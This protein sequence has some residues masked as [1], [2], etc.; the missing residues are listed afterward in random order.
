ME[1]LKH[2]DRQE[3]WYQDWIDY[4]GEHGLYASLLSPER[5]SSRRH[6]LDIAKLARFLEAFAYFSPAHGYSLHVSLLGLFPILMSAN[7]ALKKEAIA[8]LEAG[9]LF[10]FAV[11]ERAHG[12][13]LFANEFTM[14]PAKAPAGP[15]AASE[16]WVAHGAKFYIGN[17]NAACLISILARKADPESPGANKRTPFAFFAL[18]PQETT[19]LRNVTKIRTVGVRTAFVGSFEV[20][21]HTFPDR[22]I[23]SQGRAAWDAVRATVNFG[24]FFLGFGAVGI[25]EHALVEALAH[26]RRRILFGKPV[27]AMPHIQAAL[28][29]AFA[30]LM[31]MKLYAYRALDYLQAASDADRRYL[32]WGAVQKAKVSTEGVKVMDLLSECIGARAFEADSYFETALRDAQLIPSLEGSTHIN[33]ALAAQ[34]LGPY[35]ADADSG[36]PKAPSLRQTQAE[37]RENPYWLEGRDRNARTVRFAHFLQAYEP[38][39]AL[40][41]VRSFVKQVKA[42]HLFV[43]GMAARNPPRDGSVAH[44]QA[45]LAD[46]GLA[47]A[48]GKCLATIAYA[49][50]VAENCLAAEIEPAIVSVLFHSFIEDLS[51]EALKLSALYLPGGAQRDQLRDMVRVPQTDAE[52]V[53]AVAEFMAARYR[54]AK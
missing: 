14:K 24:K 31:G 53:Q 32:L 28:V 29:L 22:D 52:N 23:I 9:G 2:E 39:P 44:R 26:M 35:F 25:C 46:A 16:G 13:D 12:S 37:V 6:R 48:L 30:R 19:A 41:N 21:G 34:F 27:T 4:Q 40:P 15:D 33:F 47:I 5:Y 18:P 43:S 36:I 3:G 49:Q 20:Q 51:A 50:L 38:L 10:A 1:A 7:E 11:S 54:V 17:A 42:F 8:K 45:D